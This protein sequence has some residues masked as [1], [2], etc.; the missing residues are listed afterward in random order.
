MYVLSGVDL[1]CSIRGT[2][3]TPG[4]LV[5]LR[6]E[7]AL[8]A[9]AA[10]PVVALHSAPLAEQ[11]TELQNLALDMPHFAALHSAGALTELETLVPRLSAGIEIGSLE[12]WLAGQTEAALRRQLKALVVGAEALPS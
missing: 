10:I 12:Q 2:L 7:A 4:S 6:I 3:D 1:V 9:H 5:E 11:R 8:A